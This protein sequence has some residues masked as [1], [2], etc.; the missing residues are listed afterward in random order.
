MNSPRPVN[1]H[2]VPLWP[3]GGA[4]RANRNSTPSG[5]LMVP[6]VAPS[7]TGLAGIETSV[8]RGP[9]EGKGCKQRV[10]RTS[11]KIFSTPLQP[12]LRAETTLPYQVRAGLSRLHRTKARPDGGRVTYQSLNGGLYYA[13]L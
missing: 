9:V 10:S 8:M 3:A 1:T 2:T 12:P 7:G 5:V 11:T 6:A 13:Y 4:H